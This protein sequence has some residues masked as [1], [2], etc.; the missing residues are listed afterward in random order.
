MQIAG[1]VGGL[2]LLGAANCGP[3]PQVVPFHTIGASWLSFLTPSVLFSKTSRLFLQNTGRGGMPLLAWE[4]LEIFIQKILQNGDDLAV[5][6]RSSDVGALSHR[7]IHR[8]CGE[9]YHTRTFLL[10]RD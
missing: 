10:R 2:C 5:P 6:A 8:A 7:E 3:D 9:E 1:G 4:L